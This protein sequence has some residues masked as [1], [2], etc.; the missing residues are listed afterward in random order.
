MGIEMKTIFLQNLTGG[1]FGG[2]LKGLLKNR[3][4]GLFAR[5]PTVAVLLLTAVF[6]ACASDDSKSS[7][8]T[9]APTPPTSTADCVFAEDVGGTI[10]CGLIAL[11]QVFNSTTTYN[12]TV[13][14]VGEEGAT[15]K[16]RSRNFI[17]T[18]IING[19]ISDS[20]IIFPDNNQIELSE[21]ATHINLS[22]VADNN[23]FG[24]FYIELVKSDDASVKVR[25]TISITSVNDL[26]EFEAGNSPE[27]D[28]APA[29][30]TSPASYRFT[31][32]P[33]NSNASY[34]VGNVS[35]TDVEDAV[36]TYGIIGGTDD[37]DLFKIDPTTGEITL[38]AQ[39]STPD[40]YTFNVAATDD[41]G[42]ITMAVITVSVTTSTTTAP[43]ADCMF[44]EDVGGTV[45]CGLL[46]LTRFDSETI[47]NV[48]VGEVGEETTNKIGLSNFTFIEIINGNPSGEVEPDANNQLT[49]LSNATALNITISGI[50]ENVF[51][52][53]YIDLVK[54]DDPTIKV[55]YTI[56]I[57]PVPD[58]PE[59][60][61]GIGSGVFT[62][63]DGATPANYNFT[64]IPLNSRAGYSMGNVSATDPDGG[65][66]MYTIS[67]DAVDDG[68]FEINEATGEITLSVTAN[69][70]IEY[71]FNVTANDGNGGS[72]TATISVRVLPNEAPMFRAVV[73]SESQFI[74]VRSDIGLPSYNFAGVPI[75][76]AMGYSVGNVFA[77]DANNDDIT[78]SISNIYLIDEGSS[79]F[80][81]NALFTI[82]SATGEVT[83]SATAT[84]SD[85][86]LYQVNAT[87]TDEQ[88][89]NA[90]ATISVYVDGDAPVFSST[91]YR[92][93]LSLS[94]A[95][96]G[97]VIGNVSATDVQRTLFDYSLAKDGNLFDDLFEPATADN[98]DGSRNIILSRDADLSD[99]AA[100]SIEFQ[101]V[102]THQEGE[103]SSEATITVNLNNDLPF[104]DDFDGDGVQGFYD[105]FPHDATMNVMGDGEPGNPFIISN[106]YQLQA[107]AGVDH[108]GTA[109]DSSD[110]TGDSFLYGDDADEQLTKHYVLANN[111]DA[112]DTADATVW[113]KSAVDAD[114]FVGQGW[115]PIAGNSS[116]SFS[117][118]FNGDGYQ[119][120]DLYMRN[121]IVNNS[122]H[123]ALF[124]INS[125]NITS[126]GL[127]NIETEIQALNN[128]YLRNYDNNEELTSNSIH[129]YQGAVASLAAFNQESAII[130][131]SYVTGLV[132]GS[133]EVVGGLVGANGGELSY[134][135]STAAVRGEGATGGLVG[136]NF[137]SSKQLNTY[138]TGDV[139]AGAGVLNH[140]LD[141]E[142]S[143]F[144]AS[145]GQVGG[146]I[147]VIADAGSVVRTGYALGATTHNPI[148]G[149]DVRVGNIAGAK[150]T[151]ATFASLYWKDGG[152]PGIAVDSKYTLQRTSPG[153]Q[154]GTNSTTTA[155][156]QGCGLGGM[157]I[158]GVTPDPTCTD[159]FPFADWGNTTD[160]TAGT[161]DIERG[162]IF[163]ADE[164]P[165]LSAVRSSDDKQLF[166][167]AADQECQRNGMPLGCE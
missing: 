31:D 102:A 146:L 16:L 72:A 79:D 12:I 108:A 138:A 157:V 73:G 17:F 129:G 130:S 58:A 120:R 3:L 167:S 116:Q 81:E 91:S 35:A 111:I 155:Q 76:S 106:I 148:N 92:F 32:I 158:T 64:N 8:P 151:G 100:P 147:G 22:I 99:F 36:V 122:Q 139:H 109:L 13:V 117:G 126:V 93:D 75:N 166:P 133:G 128:H 34:L 61:A 21:Y 4:N 115:T 135:Y 87:A 156:L 114:N 48:T 52:E 94:A 74:A 124:G 131:Y 49:L 14:E 134:S 71:T 104:D 67:V 137:A 15:D 56:S 98:A 150:Y 11:P 89:A 40:V 107:V 165:S 83:L 69:V 59:F 26:P 82:N 97:V 77:T 65:D 160:S 96:D 125:G 6:A 119:I 132:N 105:A 142:D 154:T 50:A 161:F 57:T 103:F 1:L 42:G 159:L 84:V 88:G 113:N 90:I 46:T 66:P 28:F 30:S 110:F 60:V 149:P 25:Y 68:L 101:V 163:N 10:G 37:T 43:R 2:I 85:S 140:V 63:A 143:H 18:Q 20:E 33:F 53:F 144:I 78:Y 27:V 29:N 112:S 7:N 55:R 45:D 41:N 23:V 19:S 54:S 62:S 121:R 47:Y 5:T 70:A 38:K 39:A 9:T 162:W 118:S 127:I 164:Y 141:A 44:A 51:G 123:F 145:L 24:E 152:I 86:G 153:D 136:T 95:V 80:V